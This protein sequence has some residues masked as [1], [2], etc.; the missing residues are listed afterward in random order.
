MTIQQQ[1]KNR[2]KKLKE[3]YDTLKIG[4]DGL[5]KLRE[6]ADVAESVY[7]SNAI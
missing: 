7:N 5:L 1:I 3:R 6:E 2:I 4:K